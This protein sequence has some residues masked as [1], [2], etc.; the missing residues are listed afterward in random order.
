IHLLAGAGFGA[1]ILNP[2]NP[3]AEVDRVGA[4]NASFNFD[5]GG[6]GN[7]AGAVVN[8]TNLTGSGTMTVNVSGANLAVGAIKLIDCTSLSGTH[9]WVV[10]TLP[11]GLAGTI[12]TNL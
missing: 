6:F 8:I 10:G 5:L 9:S 7:P 4:T 11:P 2:T 3:P 12:V 1:R